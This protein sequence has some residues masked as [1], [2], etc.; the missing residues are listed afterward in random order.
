MD[1]QKIEQAKTE[2]KRLQSVIA[3]MAKP[4]A[5]LRAMIDGETH[6][7]IKHIDELLKIAQD[8]V[9]IMSPKEDK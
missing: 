3:S 8:R 6:V 7:Q 1:K 2:T 4:I 5:D 9:R